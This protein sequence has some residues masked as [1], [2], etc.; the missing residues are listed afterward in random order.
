MKAIRTIS[1]CLL[2]FLMVAAGIMHFVKHSFFVK[3][4]PPYLPFPSELVVLSGLCEICL[5]ILL[6]IP[7]FS[8]F[9]AWGIIALLVTV[10]PAN[11]FLYQHQ[12]IVPASP[13]VHF[14]RLIL[15]GPLILWAYWH[16]KT[17]STSAL[18]QTS[19]VERPGRD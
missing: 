12:E 7:P 10:F 2:S 1:K 11:I 15:Q 14:I 5:G 8:R 18:L 17:A 4:V 9:A 6:L 13:T 16:T 3:I 19:E